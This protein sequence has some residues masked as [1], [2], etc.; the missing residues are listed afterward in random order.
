MAFLREEG[1][2][3][4]G[5]FQDKSE[6]HADALASIERPSI[7]P[8][9]SHQAARCEPFWEILLNERNDLILYD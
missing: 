5:T 4:I 1:E 9:F 2:S 7:P 8:A 6:T 3:F